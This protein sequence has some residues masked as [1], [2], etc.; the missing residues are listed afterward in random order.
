[1]TLNIRRE[2]SYL[3]L[4]RIFCCIFPEKVSAFYWG[5]QQEELFSSHLIQ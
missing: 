5:M 4:R 2:I 3:I 1:M